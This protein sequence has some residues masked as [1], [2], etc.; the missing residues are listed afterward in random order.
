MVKMFEWSK[1]PGTT[2]NE[3]ISYKDTWGQVTKGKLAYI[4][5]D[6]DAFVALK[7]F[8]ARDACSTQD[9]LFPF[10]RLLQGTFVKKGSGIRKAL[11][12]G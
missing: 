7:K 9:L 8:K 2:T 3:F 5:D 4:V 12:Y 6:M 10:S 1:V 11:D